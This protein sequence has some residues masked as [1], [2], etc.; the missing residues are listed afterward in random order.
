LGGPE[1]EL[2]SSDFSPTALEDVPRVF[3]ARFSGLS[4]YQKDTWFW[5]RGER[6]EPDPL[7]FWFQFDTEAVWRVYL[8]LV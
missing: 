7:N 3:G 4:P 1:K 6:R 5:V 8:L 2:T